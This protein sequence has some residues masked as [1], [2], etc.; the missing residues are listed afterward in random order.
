MASATEHAVTVLSA[1]IPRRGDLLDRASQ[2][3][4]EEHFQ[5]KVHKNLWSMLLKYR[6]YT[7]TVLPRKYLDDNLGRQANPGTVQLYLETYDAFE[8]K[9]VPDSDFIWSVKELR[10][11]AAD[12]ATQEALTTAMEIVRQGKA[13]STGETLQGHAE[14]RQYVA[15]HLSAIDR[16]ATLQEAPEG[17]LQDEEVELLD[18]Y[19]QQKANRLNGTSGG[20]LFGISELDRKVGG[21]HNGELILSVGYSSDGKTSLCVQTAWSAAV[22]QGKNVVFFTTETTRVQ[23]RRKILARHSKLA[24]FGLVSGLNTRNLKEGTLTEAE[25]AVLPDVVKDLAKNPAY[26]KLFIAQIPRGSTITSLEQRMY[27]IQRQFN[28]DLVVMDY[29]ALLSPERSRQSTREELSSILKEAK[30]VATTFNNGVG[31]PFM[32]P[33]Q[34]GRVHRENAEKT[35]EYTSASLSETAEATNSSDII[36]SLM[37]PTDNT[38]RFAEITMQVLKNRD[39]ETANGILT[40]VDYATS[41]FT[42]KN[43]TGF[44][45]AITSAPRDTGLS[46]TEDDFL[47]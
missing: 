21:L 45:A 2:Q 26:G 38:N 32:S 39:G 22:E 6:D 13:L 14:A 24:Q 17:A 46:F 37:A 33:W 23:V 35:G 20:V 47:T 30:L 1:I 41:S 34:V 5:D 42:S 27:R 36:I 25:E 44:A 28:I 15:E 9:S 18:D 7:G 10:E 3:L 12:R 29:L 43:G 4:T 31:V 16:E 40:D 11:A 19:A 8:E